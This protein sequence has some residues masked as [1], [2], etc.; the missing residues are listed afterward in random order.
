MLRLIDLRG[1]ETTHSTILDALPRAELDVE[2]AVERVLPLMEDVRRHGER[3][4]IEQAEK[5][6][7]VTPTHVAVPVADID[8]AVAALDPTLRA[9]IEES[10]RRQR[11]AS[12]AQVHETTVVELAPGARVIQRWRP[13]RR[14][15]LYVPGGKAVYPSSVIM[16]VVPAQAAGVPEISVA[17]PAQEAC[18]GSIHPLIL[19]V[20]G[21]LGV[22]KVYAMGGAGAIAAFAYGVPEIDLAPVD[23]ITGPGNIYVAAAKRVVRGICGIDAEAGPTEIM[24]VAD[25]TGDP[26]LIAADLLSQAEH[27]EQAGSVLVTTDEAL[28]SAVDERVTARVAATPN[29]E[30]ATTALRG[31]QSGTILVDSLDVAVDVAN[32]YGAEHLELHTSDPHALAERIDN[33]GAIFLGA[34]SPVSLGDYSSGSNHVLPTGGQAR[35][36]SALG[37][38][39]FIRPQQL[40]DYTREGLSEL[41]DG[42]VAFAEAEYLPAH[43]E[44]ISA[45]FGR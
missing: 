42:I 4:L 34:Y 40:I 38:Y 9:A 32:A 8:A 11:D 12:A 24:I 16:N 30:R 33:A 26:D 28:A 3:A 20:C 1:R 15:G 37:A 43:G 36:S 17:S 21:L 5:F 14:V 29:S 25:S 39:S 18:G 2:Q 35:F 13:V 19:A 22:T 41:A 23:V 31:P 7:R 44:A 10:I 6:D 45:R 27:D